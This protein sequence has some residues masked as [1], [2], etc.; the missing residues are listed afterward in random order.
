MGYKVPGGYYSETMGFIPDNSNV[1][2]NTSMNNQIQGMGLD[3]NNQD[4]AYWQD[5][6]NF[7]VGLQNAGMSKLGQNPNQAFGSNQDIIG[8]FLNRLNGGEGAYNSGSGPS[9]SQ[10]MFGGAAP[11]L[12]LNRLLE[13]LRPP[14]QTP[15]WGMKPP[16]TGPQLGPETP[17]MGNYADLLKG[18]TSNPN[19]QGV[20]PPS[21]DVMQGLLNGFNAYNPRV[22]P[23]PSTNL[24]NSPYGGHFGGASPFSQ[25]GYG[26]PRGPT[27]SV[28]GGGG[29]GQPNLPPPPMSGQPP[30][31][32]GQVPPMLPQGGGPL[33]WLQQLQQQ[34]R[35]PRQMQS[36]MS[37]GIVDARPFMNQG[38]FGGQQLG[39][40]PFQPGRM[41]TAQPPS[42]GQM[43]F[44]DDPIPGG[45]P[46]IASS[47]PSMGNGGNGRAVFMNQQ[48]PGLNLN[49]DGP[50][51]PPGPPPGLSSMSIAS[52]RGGGGMPTQEQFDPFQ[53]TRVPP[54]PAPTGTG[55]TGQPPSG[56]YR[57]GASGNEWMSGYGTNIGGAGGGVKLDSLPDE[58]SKWL[59]N[60][61]LNRAFAPEQAGML[62]SYFQ[63]QG[64]NPQQTPF[65][66]GA[67]QIQYAQEQF[68]QD[69]LPSKQWAQA[70]MQGGL[71]NV[72]DQYNQSRYDQS[73]ANVLQGGQ[74]TY[75]AQDAFQQLLGQGFTGQ[76]NLQNS[77][78]Q[79][80]GFGQQQQGNA[81]QI[82][83]NLMGGQGMFTGEMK[84][85]GDRLFREFGT[86]AIPSERVGA[87]IGSVNPQ[88]VQ[89]GQAATMLASAPNYQG[90]QQTFNQIQQQASSV[91]P[92]QVNTPGFYQDMI[93]R[94]FGAGQGL[95]TPMTGAAQASSPQQVQAGQVGMPWQSTPGSIQSTTSNALE[96]MIAGGGISPQ[97]VQAMRDRVLKPSNEAL[98]GRLNQ[99]GGGQADPSSGLFQ[100]LQ[101]RQEA[102]FNNDLVI[103]G[104]N[105]LGQFTGQGAAMGQQ[106]FG[107]GYANQQLNQ[108]AQQFNVGQGMQAQLANQG[109]GQQGNQFN[110]QMQQQAMLANQNA[111]QQ[112]QQLGVNA[113]LQGLGLLPQIGGQMLGA[114]QSNQQAGLQGQG[115]SL[116]ALQGL[117]GMQGQNL[118]FGAGQQ[119]QAGLAN[120][121][122]YNQT[123]QFNVN[124][125]LQA[126]LANQQAGLQGG[127]Q[128]QQTQLQAAL[129]NQQNTRLTGQSTQDMAFRQFQQ[130]Q[131]LQNQM[132]NQYM[133]TAGMAGQ[134][135]Q[136]GFGNALGA[137]Q[138]TGGLGLQAIQAAGQQGNA[139]SQ[140]GLDRWA[141]ANQQSLG[142][143]Q[144]ANNILGQGG[145]FAAGM[146]N[147][148][149]QGQNQTWGAQNQQVQNMLQYLNQQNQTGLGQAGL[150]TDLAIERN[151]GNT[152]ADIARMT[153]LGGGIQGLLQYLSTLGGQ[154]SGQQGGGTTIKIGGGGNTPGATPPFVPPGGGG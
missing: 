54:A 87:G 23:G 19:P 151:R 135:G 30:P 129:A 122:A 8:Q 137:F 39:P 141:Q 55:Q 35:P 76:G 44:Q 126:M 145:Q 27:G 69:T 105:N 56:P 107:Q 132:Q 117:A 115:M 154:Q 153:G 83:N 101:R 40:P 5:M 121:G 63:N 14:P 43:E 18:F 140:L 90:P 116:D 33:N 98:R 4:P 73:G 80:L 71:P 11:N 16:L 68:N 34:P 28:L 106:Q 120:Q 147:P 95:Q 97:Y 100:E 124:A 45:R 2:N 41:N 110:A 152:A 138:G 113:G 38:Q 91:N 42:G 49:T 57:P 86:G 139:M 78:A 31:T 96:G 26:P 15:G 133:Q 10:Q 74:G 59:T 12:D 142:A 118:Q 143:G 123:G 6:L 103:A 114:Q 46:P 50:T 60:N 9:Q 94:A 3:T 112:T 20:I 51:G 25:G 119:L 17:G 61:Y 65:D 150:A 130:L 48:N 82:I 21:K 29:G 85:L 125:A 104:M 79:Q 66:N 89:A 58:M 7:D 13:M 72:N 109:A 92:Q 62:S 81:G 128:N 53:G 134:L 52:T 111:Q 32:K 131:D 84:Q 47:P 93:G 148:M 102:D 22:D 136:Q 99:Q 70:L 108:Q 88:N 67:G 37:G 1:A 149:L 24:D 127:S 64:F 77:I 146:V 75:G 36:P 144:L